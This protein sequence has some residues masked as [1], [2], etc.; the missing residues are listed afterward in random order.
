MAGYKEI[1]VPMDGSENSMRALD[2]AVEMAQHYNSKLVLVHV[3]DAQNLFS[4]SYAALPK[5][6]VRILQA[7]EEKKETEI[8]SDEVQGAVKEVAKQFGED[9]LSALEDTLPKDIPVETVYAVGSPKR[10]IVDL[11]NERGSDIIVMGSSGLGAV[12]SFILGSVSAYV[13]SY[14]KCPVLVVK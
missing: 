3:V 11:A 1:L 6:S 2:K 10:Y 13:I 14:A 8:K 5:A 4:Y 9:M 12:M 7:L